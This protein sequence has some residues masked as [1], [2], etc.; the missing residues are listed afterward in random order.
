MEYTRVGVDVAQATFQVEL[1]LP[2]RRKRREFQ[3][4]PEGCRAF[5]KWAQDCSAQQLLVCMESTGRNNHKLARF[6]LACGHDVRIVNGKRIRRFAEGLGLLDKTDKADAH[7]IAEYILH[8]E[9]KTS[10]WQPPSDAR[11]ALM[12]LRCHIDGLQK[13]IRQFENRLDS[14][15]ELD[16]VVGSNQTILALLR[17]ELVK[18]EQQAAATIHG[19]EQLRQDKLT[20]MRHIGVGEKVATVLLTRIDFRAFESG[21]QCARYGGLTSKREYSGTSIHRDGRISKEGPPDVRAA[22]YMAAGSAMQHDPGLRE[23]AD[24][25]KSR[26]KF[27]RTVRV[28]VARKILVRCWALIKHSAAYDPHHRPRQ[29]Q[30]T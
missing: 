19:D 8:H 30:Y 21:R 2:T 26:G 28:A 1:V 15:I 27:S 22:L 29:F 11:A 18:A 7:A 9:D 25:L 5:L 4:T 24:R 6:L 13:S 10:P 14:G 17:E 16:M 23:F 12:D 20:L 3:N